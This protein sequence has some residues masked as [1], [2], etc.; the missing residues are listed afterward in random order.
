M[1]S[2]K[3]VMTL[4]RPSKQRNRRWKMKQVKSVNAEQTVEDAFRH[5]LLN[6]QNAVLEWEPVAV[7]GK[8]IEGVHQMRVGLRCMRSAFTV[9]RPVIPKKVTA[10]LAQEMRWAGKMLDHARDLD[11]YI[12][13]NLYSKGGKAH[14]EMR[15][16]A[17]RHRKSVYG[18]VRRFIEGKRYERSNRTVRC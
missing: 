1:N 9:F 18:E 15:K 2:G 17:L 5:I 7:E 4:F 10:P 16:I 8:D 12:T 6:N 11:V 13:D 14:K 3:T